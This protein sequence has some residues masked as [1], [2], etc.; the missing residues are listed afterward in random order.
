VSATSGPVRAGSRPLLGTLAICQGLITEDQLQQALDEQTRE[1]ESG[2]TRRPLG[3]ILVSRGYLTPPQLESLLDHQQT[4]VIPTPSTGEQPGS[5]PLAPANRG[6][7]PPPPGQAFGKYT[8]VRE[9]GRGG[10]GVVYEAIDTTLSRHVALKMVRT[11]PL[12]DPERARMEEDRFLREA[13]LSANLEKHPHIVTV[14]EAGVIDGRRFLAMELIHGRPMNDWKR[15]PES[16]LRDQV[17]LLRD[18]ALAVHHAHEN[19]VIHRDLKPGNILVDAK[20][21]PHITDFGLAKAMA[22]GA[23]V[24]LTSTGMMV[25][26]PT[27]MSPE[28]AQALK[29]VD[30]RTDVYALG[31][32][33]Y[34]SLTGQT[35][36]SGE[37][38]IELLMNM[39]RNPVPPPSTV[40]DTKLLKNLDKAIEAICL[41]ALAKDPDERYSTGRELAEDLDKWL[42]HREVKVDAP[43]TGRGGGRKIAAAAATTALAGILAYAL[44]KPPAPVVPPAP[45][46]PVSPASAAAEKVE[47]KHRKTLQVHERNVNAI[48]FSPLQSTVVVSGSA[49]GTVKRWDFTKEDEPI[50]IG[51]QSGKVES[52]VFSPDGRLIAVVSEPDAEEGQGEIKIWDAATGTLRV[53]CEGHAKGVN[54]VAFTPDGRTL[55]TGGKDNAIILW[56]VATGERLYSLE[57]HTRDVRGVAITRDAT[58]LVS[59]SH[60]TSVRIWDFARRVEVARLPGESGLWCLALSPDGKL[61]ATAGHDRAVRL[62]DVPGRKALEVLREHPNAV[63]RVAFSPDGTLLASAGWDAQFVLW[64]VAT[65]KALVSELAKEQSFWGLAFSRDGKILATGDN[66][67]LVRLWDVVRDSPGK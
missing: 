27:Y 37:T 20:N 24:S 8:L 38:A 21:K 26:T 32:M 43:K 40:V 4:A 56:D 49:D 63:I 1:V 2:R 12:D 48:A 46:V 51:A 45:P 66:S 67:G 19:G 47:V 57:G 61:A 9:L 59:A 6:A 31:V 28:Q 18:A 64:S 50:T 11:D 29:T 30:R 25:G 33:L 65:R 22:Q 35:P 53:Q 5:V 52:I 36:F 54:G 13:Q 44:L 3:K 41:K 62:W 55:I 10:M 17:A 15:L 58:T 42:G 16:T 39:V 23:G 14:F 7:S 60:D 34:E